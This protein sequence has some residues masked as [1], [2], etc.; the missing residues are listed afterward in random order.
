VVPVTLAFVALAL[1]WLILPWDLRAS[2]SRARLLGA[3]A[4]FVA[5]SFVVVHFTG[6]GL[7]AGLYSI[8]VANAVFLFREQSSTPSRLCRSSSSTTCVRGRNSGCAA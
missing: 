8:A 7:A 4:V 6:F 3:P 1:A 5:A 2:P